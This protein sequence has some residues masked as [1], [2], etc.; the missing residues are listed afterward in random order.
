MNNIYIYEYNIYI[1]ICILKYMNN[2]Y[3]L[4]YMNIT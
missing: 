4:K 2:I 3:M 1:Y